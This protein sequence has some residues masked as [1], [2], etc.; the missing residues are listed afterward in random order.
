MTKKKSLLRKD[1][2]D[3]KDWCLLSDSDGTYS[4]RESPMCA[5]ASDADF[6]FWITFLWSL[7]NDFNYD[8]FLDGPFKDTSII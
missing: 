8:P 1:Q 5:I 7:Y 6:Q 2:L 4:R 3:L